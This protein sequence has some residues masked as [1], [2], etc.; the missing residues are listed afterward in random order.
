M[1]TINKITTAFPIAPVLL[2]VS[3][4]LILFSHNIGE[5]T[6]SRT[7]IPLMAVSLFAI[8]STFL[9]ELLIGQ[10]SNGLIFSSV[11]M[12][13]FFSFSDLLSIT[14]IHQNVLFIFLVILLLV[15]FRILKKTG[16]DTSGLSGY[17]T[18]I[19]VIAMIIPLSGIIRYEFIRRT[20]PKIRNPAVSPGN[21]ILPP[22]KKD[23][24]DIYYIITD[25]YASAEVLKNNFSYDNSPFMNYL[26]KKGF[27]VATQATSNYPKTFLSLTSS[28]NMEYLDFL[29]IYKKSTDQTLTDRLIESNNVL[30]FL[31]SLGYHYYQMGSWWGSTHYNRLADDNFIIEKESLGD[32]GEF[33]YMIVKSSLLNPF[34]NSFIPGSITGE[35]DDAKRAR[36]L[37]QF[38]KLPDVAKLPGPKFVF[39]HIISPHSPYV[40]NR[41]CE[42][43]DYGRT[44]EIPEGQ[45]YVS[46]I[47]CLNMKLENTID[48]I[49]DH[50][51][52]PPVIL[53]QA[54]EGPNFLNGQLTP[55]DNWKSAKDLQLKEK[56]PIL[57]AY[58]LPGKPESSLS[59]SM[60]PVNSFRVIFNLYFSSHLPLLPDRNFIFQ[61]TDHLYEFTDVTSRIRG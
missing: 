50:S 35:S 44:R 32:I 23:L 53:I 10:R 45:N 47:N 56:F 6:L 37:Y 24:P 19:S 41:N 3:F 4:V 20:Q 51:P 28:L 42:F 15:I 9:S 30:L 34:M 13:I 17:L 46:Q 7:I 18:T 36:V 29:S 26:E 59:P 57:S 54:D 5:L 33:N 31:K 11:F 39:T 2:S 8:A 61:D 21:Y 49:V 55:P 27:F 40:F 58:Y 25:S 60:T 1:K 12:L 38:E 52:N 22:G 48:A 16:W 43:T 14:G